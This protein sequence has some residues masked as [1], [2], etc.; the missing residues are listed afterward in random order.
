[1]R[2][3]R[4][5][6]RQLSEGLSPLRLVRLLSDAYA[7]LRK[8]RKHTCEVQRILPQ[9]LKHLSTEASGSEAAISLS[10]DATSIPTGGYCHIITCGEIGAD[11]A[12]TS[13]FPTLDCATVEADQ[14]P[15]AVAA[16]IAKPMISSL[17][18]GLSLPSGVKVPELH[19]EPTPRL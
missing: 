11:A 13:V 6:Q 19:T 16:T 1:M 14:T 5:Q 15:N 18:I 8:P 9:Q 17:R 4:P 12:S 3:S 2:S 7:L 10:K